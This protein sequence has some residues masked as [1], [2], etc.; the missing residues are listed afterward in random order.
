MNEIKKH[1]SKTVGDYDT[2][3]N[4]VVFK[5]DELHNELVKAIPFDKNKMLNILDLGCW[6]GHWID[7]VAQS[8]PKSHI[9]GIDFSPSM[10]EKSK[11]NL[12]NFSDRIDLIEIDFNDYEFNKKF[13]VVI[14]AVAVHNITHKQKEILFKKIFNSL[15]KNWVFINADFYE[16]ESKIINDNLKRLYKDFLKKNLYWDELEVWLR[17]A[18]KEDMPMKLS[19][20]SDI[21][22]RTGFSDFKLIWLFNN[23]A[24]YIVN[25]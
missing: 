21:L 24:V 20:Q 18:F 3:A 13:D 12:L 23:E 19:E 11:K 22:K 25:K 15:N 16:S 14:S 2:V 17:H 6:T 4:R 10:I 7:L 1:F 5:N 9:T 8:F